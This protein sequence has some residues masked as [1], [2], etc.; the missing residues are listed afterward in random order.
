MQI[1]LLSR[2]IPRQNRPTPQ[3][4]VEANVDQ[5]LNESFFSL[6]QSY[7]KDSFFGNYGISHILKWEHLFHGKFKLALARRL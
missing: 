3:V 4:E 6:N 1:I 2:V 7:S 5:S